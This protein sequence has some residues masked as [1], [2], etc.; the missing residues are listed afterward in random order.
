MI[1]S[2][3]LSRICFEYGFSIQFLYENDKECEFKIFRPDKQ[4]YNLTVDKKLNKNN[5]S[6]EEEFRNELIEKLTTL[7]IKQRK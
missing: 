4:G 2:D 1:F 6:S 7:P 3:I 5:Y